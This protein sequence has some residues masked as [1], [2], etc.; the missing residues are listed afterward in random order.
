MPLWRIYHAES[1][2][3]DAQKASLA[4][5]ITKLYSPSSDAGLPRF[6]TNVVFIP[7]SAKSIFVGG[8]PAPKFVRFTIEQI[9]RTFKTNDQKVAWLKRIDTALKP[10]LGDRGDLTWEY[11]IAE[12]GREL[13]E[14]NGIV[15][16]WQG[17]E[18]EKRWR[19]ENQASLY[20]EEDNVRSKL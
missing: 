4:A 5:S 8:E 20:A 11:H 13:W 9:A 1:V 18:A 10:H 17:T 15:P 12:T 19:R 7:L 16:P 3:T 6:Y 14:V 2:F